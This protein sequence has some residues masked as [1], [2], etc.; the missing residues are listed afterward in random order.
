MKGHCESEPDNQDREQ[1]ALLCTWDVQEPGALVP[2]QEE[3]SAP[4]GLRGH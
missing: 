2:E 3:A 4:S 1:L